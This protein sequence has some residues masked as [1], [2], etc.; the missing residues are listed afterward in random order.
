MSNKYK[1]EC[2]NDCFNCKWPDCIKDEMTR[3]ER[4]AQRKRDARIECS[5]G[6][7][8]IIVRTNKRRKR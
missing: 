7:P 4:A 6:M 3:E 2:D 5:S 8:S 1:Y